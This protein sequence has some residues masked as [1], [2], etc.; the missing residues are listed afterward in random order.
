VAERLEACGVPIAA[1]GAGNAGLEVKALP[2]DPREALLHG[3]A[4]A[5]VAGTRIRWAKVMEG[6]GGRRVHLPG[7]PF[8]RVRCWPEP[9]EIR[10][11]FEEQE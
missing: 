10:T 4:L 6:A 2:D 1:D 7:Y 8:E 3:V 5:Y 9:A 11:T